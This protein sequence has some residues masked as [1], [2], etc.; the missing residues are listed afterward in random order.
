MSEM[1]LRADRRADLDAGELGS[2][3][4][5]ADHY[6]RIAGTLCPGGCGCRL[7]TDDADRFECGCDEGCCN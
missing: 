1:G 3:L 6:D 5:D 2:G 4:T 7:G